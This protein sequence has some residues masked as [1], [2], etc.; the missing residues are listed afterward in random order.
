MSPVKFAIGIL[1]F[2]LASSNFALT[3]TLCNPMEPGALILKSPHVADLHPD[4][5]PPNSIGSGWGLTQIRREQ[6][7]YSGRLVSSRGA[8]QPYRVYVVPSQ[9]QCQ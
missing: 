9:W 3:Q 1:A 2:L 4:W 7:F 5:V 8:I 6:G